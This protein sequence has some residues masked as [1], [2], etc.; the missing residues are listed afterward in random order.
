MPKVDLSL[1]RMKLPE[2]KIKGEGPDIKVRK[3]DMP[4]VDISLPKG[5][6][7]MPSIDISLPKGKAKGEIDIEG[8]SGKGGKIDLPKLDISL[9]KVK[10]PEVDISV[11]GPDIKGGKF[12][13]PDID[14]SLP[15]GKVK[16]GVD[17]EGEF[18]KRGKFH[19]PKVEFSIPKLKS[20]KFSPN[21]E[22]SDVGKITMPAID[23]SLPKGKAEGIGDFEGDISMLE[24]LHM[25]ALELSLPKMK[26]PTTELK[27]HGPDINDINMP[28]ASVCGSTSGNF[29]L[30]TVK[31]PSVDI[32]APK[33]DLDFG[34]PKNKGTDREDI[35]LLKAEGSRPSSGASFDIPEK[36]LKMPKISLPKFVGKFKSEDN[37]V[38]G[39]NLPSSLDMEK[40]MPS[41]G[42]NADGKIK[43]KIK[44]LKPEGDVNTSLDMGAEGKEHFK[45]PTIDTKAKV[46]MPSVEISLPAPYIPEREALL[47]KSE[48]DVSEADFKAYEGSLKIPK[49]PSI[50]ISVAKV[51]LDVVIPKV[52]QDVLVESTSSNLNIE[53]DNL[54]LPHIKMPN[55]DILLPQG[56]TGGTDTPE[57]EGKYGKFK[58]AKIIMPAVEISLPHG[59]TDVDSSDL[60]IKINSEKLKISD[61]KVP[62]MD[63]SVPHG[64][65]DIEPPDLKT[66]GQNAK[67]KLP[68]I[69]KTTVDISLPKGKE[70]E[71]QVQEMDI[72]GWQKLNI[73]TIDTQGPQKHLELDIR[74]SKDGKNEKRFELPNI[75]L[76][77]LASKEKVKGPKVKG[78]KF[79]IGMPK[80]KT[81]SLETDIVRSNN[82]N[83]GQPLSL[84]L[85]N[86]KF[87]EVEIFESNVKS[88][89]QGKFISTE[90]TPAD[91]GSCNGHSL[92]N[93]EIKAPELDFGTVQDNTS[94][95]KMNTKTGTMVKIP[96]FD[97]SP[98]SLTSPEAKVNIKSPKGSS[99]TTNPE[100][101]Y[102]GPHIPKVTKAVFVL[103]NS[104]TESYVNVTSKASAE[105]VDEKIKVP[106]IIHK[107]SFEK[108]HSKG[109]GTNSE[110]GEENDEALKTGAFR[111]P[112][113]EFSS[114]YPKNVGEEDKLKMGMEPENKGSTEISKGTKAKSGKISF[115]GFKKKS[116]KGDEEGENDCIVSSKARLEMLTEKQGSESPVPNI[117]TDSGK[118][119]GQKEGRSKEDVGSRQ[120]AEEKEKSTWF[121]IP[122]VTLSPHSTGT[123]QISSEGSPKE[124]KSSL[125][126]SSEEISGGFYR[127]MPNTEFSTQEVSS[128][129]T[130]TTT[131]EGTF[132]VVTKT[133]K[134]KVTESAS[135][136]S[137]T[138][139]N[140]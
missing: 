24:K 6:V 79:N 123:L 138:H 94:N 106:K 135:S 109:K 26:S 65:V 2:G 112:K 121:K 88:K 133:S 111:L 39:L 69:T 42:I 131:K 93:T 37:Q 78:T 100:V 136:S 101:Q 86:I 103:A 21:A 35:E 17:L 46:K 120:E 52:K 11:E 51:D 74:L 19:M 117:S 68:N 90:C 61:V 132:T 57:V 119:S 33:V 38:E 139:W 99:M 107:P 85:S 8:Q 91:A 49:M 140:Q 126:Y 29:K 13:M 67:F 25:P 98:P 124:S 76:S 128:K 95:D 36:T 44:K 50:D 54:T 102:E 22:G 110:E 81:S 28:D 47:P 134:Y 71:I 70:G 127:R 75:D 3:V 130:V 108:S 63:I 48:I 1:P 77:P 97:V 137:T 20:P 27:I 32:S 62:N 12:H 14:I 118:T 73:S 16:G 84:N 113:L 40:N 64:R 122:K 72:E 10:P 34:I 5:K 66:E 55:V 129:H 80:I 87:P 59:K 89:C 92:P 43:G 60:D 31:L 82:V 4:S 125:Q 53:R 115:P 58:I 116:V 15:K 104:Q 7:D 114:L 45:A 18:D 56:R 83:A 96:K 9:P 23:Q 41:V 30:T 105:T